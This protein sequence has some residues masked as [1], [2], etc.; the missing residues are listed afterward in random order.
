MKRL[1]ALPILLIAFALPGAAHAA[2]LKSTLEV[3]GWIPYWR[4]ATGTQDVIPRISSLTTVHPF[5]YIVTQDGVVSDPTG[6]AD[7]PWKSLRAAAKQNGVRFIPT[8]MWGDGAAMHRILSNAKT[9]QALEDSIADLVVREG[10]D[11]I[12]IDFEGKYA[13]TRDY[14]STFL[15]GLYSRIGKK[16]VYCTI[17]SRTPLDS[18]YDSTPPKDAGIYANDFVQINKYCDRVQIMAYDQGAIDVKLNGVAKGPYVPVADIAWVEKVMN[19]AAQSISKKKLVLGIPTYGY[20][21]VVTP[22]PTQGYSYSRL[23]AFNPKYATDLAMS[24]GI[25]P[26]R[27]SAGELQLTY[28]A[29]S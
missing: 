11:G 15:K 24:L 10:F 20:E 25:N 3:S 16:W 28:L 6:F 14:F 27:N 4:A 22:L 8:V 13:E 9:R 23:W 26:I 19:V 5:G 1:F 21:Y 29:T 18:R 17:E 2:P 7:E 12:D